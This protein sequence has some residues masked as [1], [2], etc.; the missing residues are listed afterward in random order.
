MTHFKQ[1]PAGIAIIYSSFVLVLVSFVIY[2]R[3]QQVDLVNDDYYD[4]EMNYQQQISRIGRTQSF[5]QP[6]NWILMNKKKSLM[7]QF[8][9]DFDPTLLRGT[10]LFFRPSDAK[11]DKLVVLN[12]SSDGNQLISTKNMTPGLWKLKIFW[13]IN[14]SEYYKEGVLVLE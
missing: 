2:S 13:Q 7:I 14:N 8:S 9:S 1:W 10:I 3:Y 11:Q 5:S 4:Q 6:V 12:L